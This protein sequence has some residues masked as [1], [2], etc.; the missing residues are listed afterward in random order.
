MGKDENV[1]QAAQQ[2][3]NVVEVYATTG[4][5]YDLVAKIEG[6]EENELRDVLREIKGLEGVA[7]TLTSIIYS[8]FS[9]S[10]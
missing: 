4:G 9:Q 2:L 3:G 1:K 8:D 5:I 6:K 10:T 7:S